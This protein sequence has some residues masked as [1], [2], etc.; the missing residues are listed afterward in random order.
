MAP[1][2]IDV[3]PVTNGEFEGFVEAGGYSNREYWSDAG[4]HWLQ[5]SAVA[6]PKFEPVFTRG[7][8]FLLRQCTDLLRA[9]AHLV[10]PLDVRPNDSGRGAPGWST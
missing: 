4:W 2:W 6:A 9:R 10:E 5:S 1:F 8:L 7:A 3:H